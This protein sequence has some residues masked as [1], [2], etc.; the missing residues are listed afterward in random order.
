MD[1]KKA[2]EEAMTKLM[3]GSK[4]LIVVDDTTQRRSTATKVM[5]FLVAERKKTGV[6]LR[7][8]LGNLSATRSV[9]WTDGKKVTVVTTTNLQNMGKKYDTKLDISTKKPAPAKT[10]K[11]RMMVKR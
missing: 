1:I 2:C 4:L 7:T 3:L 10:R 9:E 6:Y 8:P 11:P 5:E